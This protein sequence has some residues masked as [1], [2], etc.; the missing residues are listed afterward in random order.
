[1]PRL[2]RLFAAVMLFAIVGLAHTEVRADP[3]AITSGFWTV[4]G[5]NADN[6]AVMSGSGIAINLNGSGG[7][8]LITGIYNPGTLLSLNFGTSALDSIT[9]NGF[10]NSNL[11]YSI[12]NTF[13]FAGG[14]FAVPDTLNPTVVMPFTFTGHVSAS[15]TTSPFMQFVDADLVGQGT[16]T[17]SFI[18]ITGGNGQRIQQ[19][20]SITDTFAPAAAVPEPATMLLLG[21]GLAGVAARVRKRRRA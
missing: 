13:Q 19:L 1:M 5:F 21:T 17:M 4:S 16:A 15:T 18:S 14:S 7:H 9:V 12:G 3:V 10:S 6:H 8:G 20:Q 2:E 11:L